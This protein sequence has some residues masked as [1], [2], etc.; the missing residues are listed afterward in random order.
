ME[1]E[2]NV[3]KFRNDIQG[4]RGLAI[5]LVIINHFSHSI[6]PSG[7]LGVDIFFVISG[8]VIT[9]SIIKNNLASNISKLKDFF[10]K[11]IAR[12]LPSLVIYLI[13]IGFLIA[14]FN[15]FPERSLKTGFFAIFGLSNFFLFKT[16]T[17]Y[18][19]DSAL[20]NP[21]TQTWSLGIEEQYYLV[22]PFLIFIFCK[23]KKNLID[24]NKLQNILLFLITAS[25]LCFIFFYQ[26]NFNAVY[27]L[28]IFRIWELSFGCLV[29]LKRGF[30]S[31][32]ISFNRNLLVICIILIC[33]IPIEYG[34]YATILVC[35]ISAILVSPNH[36]K[37]EKFNI[38]NNKFLI[39]IGT[40]SYSLYLWHWGVISISKWILPLNL[41]SIVFELVLIF[42]IS[43]LNY[44]YIENGFRNFILSLKNI[45]KFLL[46]ISLLGVSAFT[47]SVIGQQKDNIYISNFTGEFK[48]KSFVNVG[49]ELTCEMASNNPESNWEKCVTK[50]S[51]NSIF[52]F[53]DSHSTNLL[54]SIKR[55]ISQIK[56]NYEVLYFSNSLKYKIPFFENDNLIYKKFLSNLSSGDIIIYSH[57]MITKEVENKRFSK[58]LNKIIKTV[59]DYIPILLIDDLISPCNEL[60]YRRRFTFGTSECRLSK[61]E[62]I[63]KRSKYTKRLKE[64]ALKENIHYFDPLN[65]V[66]ESDGF[67]YA[68]KNRKLLYSDFSPHISVDSK[69]VLA[70]FFDNV[71]SKNNFF[72]K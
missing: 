61:T 4:L 71:F 46:S 37:Y 10:G 57:T 54:P 26:Q 21:F 48:K 42:F 13:I 67:C 2:L 34:M 5:I 30:L 58:E 40:I 66:C 47:L 14:I 70:E 31:K 15:P 62:A 12:I 29:F 64:Y 22:Y 56:P 38:L 63:E 60:D 69:F 43:L 45:K 20:I 39:F 8:Y 50:T 68:T 9:G 6:L 27:Y 17:A 25:L 41:I 72:Q 53:G 32:F 36:S 24:I 18:F 33:F 1:K 44:K 16:S 19:G 35:L 52:I 55:S 3:I 7:Y 11:R 28:T 65:E 51:E 59:P 49:Q 23:N